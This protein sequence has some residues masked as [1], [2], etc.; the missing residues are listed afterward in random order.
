MCNLES[1]K[2]NRISLVR[3]LELLT[4]KKCKF[5]VCTYGT[6]AMLDYLDNFL[7]IIYRNSV[8]QSDLNLGHNNYFYT[9]RL[10][11]RITTFRSE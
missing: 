6:D 10:R 5:L 1:N 8:S 7:S 11:V 4:G 3:Q 9:I 2:G